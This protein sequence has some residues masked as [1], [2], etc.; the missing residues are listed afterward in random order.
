[1]AKASISV[2]SR[3]YQPGTRTVVLPDLTSDDNGA[4]I[5]MTRESWQDTGGDIISGLVEG[6]ND[7]AT[8]FALMSFAYPGGDEIN[9]R[10]GQPV[11]FVQ[12][13]VTWPESNGVPQRPAQV[14]ATITNTVAL[15]TAITLA[16]Y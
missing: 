13:T 10:T 1:M 2:P 9:P 8:W 14:R 16:G 3:T 6:S 5:T 7:G 4:Q 15:T 11:L 12:P